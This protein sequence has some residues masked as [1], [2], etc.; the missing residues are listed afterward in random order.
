MSQA[1]RLSVALAMLG[2]AGLR[3]CGR[4]YNGSCYLRMREWSIALMSY[5]LVHEA[6]LLLAVEPHTW[7]LPSALY[8]RETGR[9]ITGNLRSE[10]LRLRYG[11]AISWT[12]S[13]LS[14]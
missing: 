3:A 10:I 5:V 12:W 6:A 1:L 2:L 4:L 9:V 13:P 7:L 14:V 11:V 8:G